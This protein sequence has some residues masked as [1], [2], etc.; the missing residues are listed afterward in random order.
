MPDNHNTDAIQTPYS[1]TTQPIKILIL[2]KKDLKM[3]LK[4]QSWHQSSDTGLKLTRATGKSVTK[5]AF[6]GVTH[7]FHSQL[8]FSDNVGKD[9]H[10]KTWA[11]TKGFSPMLIYMY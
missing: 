11:R 8:H 10:L 4:L 3:S 9:T 2:V 5:T 7:T 6:K 1:L